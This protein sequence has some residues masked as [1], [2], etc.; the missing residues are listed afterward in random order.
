MADEKK[1]KERKKPIEP[2]TSAAPGKK[3]PLAEVAE[4]APTPPRTIS[5]KKPKL[6]KKDKSRLPRRQKKA[7]QKVTASQGKV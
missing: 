4:P 6:Q 5:T 2:E 3:A 1:P 7:Q